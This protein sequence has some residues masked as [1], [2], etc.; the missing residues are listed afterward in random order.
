M[1]TRNMTFEVRLNY[2]AQVI[3]EKNASG[4]TVK[5]FCEGQGCSGKTFFY[6]QKKLREAAYMQMSGNGEALPG[7]RLVPKGFTEVKVSKS[8]AYLPLQES[9]GRGELRAEISGV[10]ITADS[11]YPVAG[12]A[13]LIRRLALP[14]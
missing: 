12:L 13:D 1:N 10:L 4:K 8:K 5:E 2:W 7:M 9:T 11:A 14:C 6:W 3:N